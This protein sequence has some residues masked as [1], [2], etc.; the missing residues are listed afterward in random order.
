MAVSGGVAGGAI[1]VKPP[2]QV[3]YVPSSGL[4]GFE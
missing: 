4:A 3:G 1:E 2:R